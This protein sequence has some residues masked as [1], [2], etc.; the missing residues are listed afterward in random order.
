MPPPARVGVWHLTC[1]HAGRMETPIINRRFS[2]LL[3]PMATP[4]GADFHNRK[5]AIDSFSE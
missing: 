2:V 1:R 4:D 3:A 5:I